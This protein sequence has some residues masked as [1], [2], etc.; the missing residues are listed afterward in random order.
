M[1]IAVWHNLPSGG[2]KRA[3]YDHVKGLKDRAHSIEVYCPDSAEVNYLG[4]RPFGHVHR[5]PLP[6]QGPRY[7]WCNRFFATDS[8]RCLRQMLWHCQEAAEVINGSDC[9]VVFVNS[10][11]F[12]YMSL[13]SL[14]LRKPC[15]IYLGEPYRHYH[16]AMPDNP[17]LLGG[18]HRISVFRTAFWREFLRDA[19]RT[20]RK[21]LQ[22]TYE[23][24]SA[25]HYNRILVNSSYSRESVLRAYG[26][27]SQ[28]CYLGID[29]NRFHPS[30]ADKKDYVISVGTLT[31]LKGPDRIIAAL[32]R[33]PS[34]MRPAL[35]WVC[36]D[37]DASYRR[38]IEEQARKA[39]VRLE[40][41]VLISDEELVRQLQE[42]VA[43]VYAP[44][45]EPFGL[46]PL[47]ANACGTP[48]I[49]VAEGGVRE[50][51]EDGVNGILVRDALPDS[52]AQAIRVLIENPSLRKRLSCQAVE[53]V[54]ARWNMGSGID[55]IET[56]LAQV[57]Q[58]CPDGSLRP[59]H[60][61]CATGLA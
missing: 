51:I 9:D 29:A 50:T 12:L 40:V 10:C 47:E 33:V 39:D 37:E 52:I 15:L 61:L 13:L 57:A 43:M 27:D 58:E 8:L 1:R 2:G 54:Q 35:H 53:H 24:E 34:H 36:N 11:R 19:R 16:E 38:R 3:L 49:G 44:R 25:R 32:A 46:A 20:F 60:R 31:Y 48:T 5:F 14:F 6:A 55:R 30:R 4:L 17:W 21:R 56:H 26:L 41:F 22:M 7:A 23:I 28:V 59:E 45:L 42:A 18:F